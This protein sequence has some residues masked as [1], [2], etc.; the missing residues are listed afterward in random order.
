MVIN[1]FQN[2]FFSQQWKVPI[3]YFFL[4]KALLKVR[5]QYRGKLPKYLKHKQVAKLVNRGGYSLKN[6]YTLESEVFYIGISQAVCIG[7][8]FA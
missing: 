3:G 1:L 8:M 5:S 4:N 7:L 2:L 6:G